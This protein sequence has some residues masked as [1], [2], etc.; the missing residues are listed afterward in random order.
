MTA[1][2]VLAAG[3]HIQAQATKKPATPPPATAAPLPAPAPK[4]ANLGQVLATVNNEKITKGDLVDF[5]SRYEIPP[6]NHEQIYH[7]AIDTL[8]NTK[9]VSEYL[10]RQKLPVSE[11]RINE[12]V[13][14]LEKQ[15]K[16]D[17]SSL[18]QALVDSNK[19]MAEVKSEYAN[20]IRWIDYVKLRGTDAELKKFADTHKDLLSGTQVRA[21]HILLRVEPK[22][23]PAEKQQMRQKLAGIKRDIEAKKYTFAEAA[24]KYS[25]DPANSESGGG[26]IGFFGLNSGIVEEFGKVAFG[27]KP[28]Q[29]SEPVETPYGFHLI[30]VT[31]R[32]DR[33]KIDFEQNKTLIL[34]AYSAELQKEI[35]MAQRKT[36]KIDVKPMP[37]D[38]FPPEQPAPAALPGN[39][40]RPAGTPAPAG[41]PAPA[42][43]AAIPGTTKPR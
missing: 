18:A 5:L 31:D 40:S 1:V 26:D 17:G 8:I 27:Q 41:A 23:T 2:G 6:E 10:A 4:P 9:L 25:E 32:Q 35:L 28:G 34:N 21:S 30:M 15:L 24:N 16:A 20:R 12:A 37:P 43:K 42:G 29:I 13:A 11:D 3:T 33:P 14:Q 7:D 39:P 22:T 38:L 19:S 36:A